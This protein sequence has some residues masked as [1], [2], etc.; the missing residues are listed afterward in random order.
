MRIDDFT[1]QKINFDKEGILLKKEY[2]INIFK[3]NLFSEDDFK[4]IEKIEQEINSINDFEFNKSDKMNF[5]IIQLIRAIQSQKKYTFAFGQIK[6]Y[7][8]STLLDEIIIFL[9]EI[10]ENRYSDDS[11]PY[12]IIFKDDV[13]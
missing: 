6:Q 2:L 1:I 3:H 9:Q 12:L 8:N 11:L 7:S 13:K 10:Q 4:I 5:R